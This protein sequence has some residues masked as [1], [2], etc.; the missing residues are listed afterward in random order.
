MFRGKGNR[1]RV[2]NPEMIVQAADMDET[3]GG[4][5]IRK[6]DN[7][8]SKCGGTSLFKGCSYKEW[9]KETDSETQSPRR[10]AG[11]KAQGGLGKQRKNLEPVAKGAARG[12]ECLQLSMGRTTGVASV[13]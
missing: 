4:Q 6:E 10:C 2:N 7:Q 5:R 13:P 12:S 3:P 9:L 1:L 8:A 11:A